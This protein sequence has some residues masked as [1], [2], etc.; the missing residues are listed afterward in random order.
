MGW[1]EMEEKMFV[2]EKEKGRGA[3]EMRGR[4]EMKVRTRA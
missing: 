2:E 4:T 3:A 1:D